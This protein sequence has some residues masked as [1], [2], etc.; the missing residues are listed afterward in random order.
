[1]TE[2][3]AKKRWCPMVRVNYANLTDVGHARAEM[4][5][6]CIGSGCMMW[7]TSDHYDDA[8]GYC[9]LAGTPE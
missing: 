9:G 2:E 7:R 4:S 1:M 8:S 3:D 6:R 5:S